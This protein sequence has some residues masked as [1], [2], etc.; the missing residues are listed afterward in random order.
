MPEEKLYV[1][2]VNPCEDYLFAALRVMR[3]NQLDASR[4]SDLFVKIQTECEDLRAEFGELD[5]QDTIKREK[6]TKAYKARVLPPLKEYI[7]IKGPREIRMVPLDL[8]RRLRLAPGQTLRD[9]PTD[10]LTL[11]EFEEFKKRIQQ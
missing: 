4:K 9:Y 2:N 10:S 3:L 11:E 8:A 5:P 6:L 7:Q 1:C